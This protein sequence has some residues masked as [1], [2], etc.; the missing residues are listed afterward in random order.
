MTAD[1]TAKPTQEDD[2]K[3]AEELR[4]QYLGDKN[5]EVAAAITAR[6]MARRLPH[7][8][9]R[10]LGL[11]W[12]VDRVSV[13]VLLICQVLSGI[14]GA[15]G[16]LATSGTIKALIASGHIAERLHQAIPSV[17]VIAVAAGLRSLLGITISALSSRISP[18]IAREA[19]LMLLD[20][21]TNAELTAYDRPGYNDRF[22]AADRGADVTKD[23][24]GET[25]NVMASAASLIAAAGVLTVLHPVLLP[26]LILASLPQGIASVR[27][28]R[29]SYLTMMDTFSDRRL[30]GM[31]R[32]YLVDKEAADQIRSGTMAPYLLGKYRAA[33]DRI[34]IATNSAAWRSAKVY[35]LGALAA[36]LASA[37]VWGA[38]IVLLATGHM[39]VASA[40]TAVFALGAAGSGLHGI[41]GY[42]ADL[43]RSGLYLDDWSKFLDEAG[44]HRLSRGDQVPATPTAVRV[45]NLTY[46]YPS[47]DSPSLE[48]VSLEVR[49]GEVLAL[50][51]E[52]GSGKTTLSKLLAGLYLPT[53]GAVT[54]DGV[55]T[56]DLDPHA[57]WRE[58]GVVPQ[59]YARFPMT[60][61]ENITLGQPHGGD[62]AV[63]RAAL[64]SGADDVLAVL[65]N[66][67]ETLLAREMWGG[68]ELSGGQWQR[69][70]IARA[71]HR[72]AGLLVLDEPTSALD[73]R[74][75][76]RI[77]SGLRELARDRA[78]VLVSHRLANIAM[79]DRIVVLD[80]GRVIQSGTFTELVNEPG[81]FREL[82][83][84]Q[85]DRGVPAP[86]TEQE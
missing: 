64:A 69:I 51:G 26:L 57:L 82:W 50:V 85:N 9:R 48:K 42:G 5:E 76:H 62:E 12:R 81:L 86:R 71:F 84:L 68:Q 24:I 33:G 41:V 45:E 15:F 21:G 6:N 16:L 75:E 80:H 63:H 34:T 77:F 66:D 3:P 56:R 25:Q 18:K 83:L 14:L 58:T 65:R 28:A 73:P 17:A 10:T 79:A 74:A 55:D 78:V 35:I 7:L 70:A 23:L 49:R 52:N 36:G 39:S 1:I 19:E 46:T 40:G 53:D 8:M 31:L 67:L 11:A 47:S 20:A 13:V 4:Y 61:R 59:N 44:G 38:V 54:W 37:L 60:A 27:A 22:D 29:I 32:W 72:P 2:P 43:Y 30:L